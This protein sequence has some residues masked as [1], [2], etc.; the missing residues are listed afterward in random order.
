MPRKPVHSLAAAL[1]LAAVAW[2]GW[3][4]V[5]EVRA[6]AAALGAPPEPGL[7]WR[8]RLGDPGPTALASFLADVGGAVPAG[9]VV[10]LATATGLP[11]QDFFLRQWAAYDLPEQRVIPL[12]Q[13]PPTNGYRPADFVVSYGTVIEDLRLEEVLRRPEGALYRVPPWPGSP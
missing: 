2:L 5:R 6:A 8:W 12:V 10:A 3:G 7:V 1:A 9:S 4:F 13:A 11:D